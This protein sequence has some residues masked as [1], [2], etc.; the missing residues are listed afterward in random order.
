MFLGSWVQKRDPDGTEVL[1]F[2]V[3]EENLS[4]EGPRRKGSRGHS[5]DSL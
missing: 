5:L 3:V 1:Y 4:G 2:E